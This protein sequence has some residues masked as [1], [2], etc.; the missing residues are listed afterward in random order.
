MY[1]FMPMW[2]LPCP[3][4]VLPWRRV[5]AAKIFVNML[6]QMFCEAASECARELPLG[7]AKSAFLFAECL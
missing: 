7:L 2:A 6:C 4:L 3:A 1:A 5:A